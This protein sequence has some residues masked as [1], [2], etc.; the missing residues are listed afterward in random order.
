LKL[1]LITAAWWTVPSLV[2]LMLYWPGLLAWFQQDDFVWLNLPNQAHGWHGL[3]HTLFAPTV[4]GTWRPLSERVFFLTFG[5]MFGAHALPYR[6]WVFLTQFANLV[7]LASITTRLTRSRAAG[8]WAAIL[9]VANSKLATV[10]S[11]SC[12]YIL[13]L[14]GFF[15]LLGLH[16]FLRYIETS[17]RRYY[18]WTWAVFLCGFLAMES[19]VVFPLLVGSYTLLCARKYFRATLPFFAA[20]AVYAILHLVLAPNH[21]TVAYTMHI[22]GAIPATVWTYWR[23]TF[24]PV[25][26]R[27]LTPFSPV[28]GTAQMA[29][30]SLALIGFTI[31]QAWRRQWLALVLLAWYG[32]TLG[33]VIPL[34]DHIT[35]YYLTL[36]AMCLAMLAGYALASA[37]R[38]GP[39]WKALS[40]VVAAA[41]LVQSLPVAWRTAEWYRQRAERQ[42]TLVMGVARAHE[43]HPGKV[44]LLDGVPDDLFWGAVA[45]R[46]F[47]FLRIPDV[48]LAPGWEAH[49]TPHGEMDD[50]STFALPADETLQ[51]LDDD[52]VEVYRVGHGPLKNITHHYDVPAGAAE[53]LGLARIDMSDP[54]AGARL[55]PTWFP[56]EEGFRW[57]PRTA[58]VHMPGPR[59]AGQKLYLTAICQPAQVE[60]GPLGMTVT[61]DGVRLAPVQF[62]KGSVETTFAL[63]LPGEVV[64]KRDIEITVEVSRTAKVGADT[65]EL[66]LAFGRF[67][68]R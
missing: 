22:D 43:L 13:V 51:G 25:N 39:L 32:I 18:V 12:E 50:V 11:W 15:L 46:P 1:K 52:R 26:L 55:G 29:A 61:V 2:C 68:I 16:F 41:F 44:I 31:Y 10:M 42:K 33:P 27:Y 19:N 49:I 48:Y 57:M 5:W 30:C 60:K 23:R 36:P 62:T 20:S 45:Q 40:A 3:L 7:L 28:E 64:G 37:W 35:D 58:S 17:E 38:A 47:L 65:R 24:E 63:G 14:C 9:W 6:I 56:R 8:F 66:G 34:R 54:L 4:Q 59:T 21:G 53:S 67:E